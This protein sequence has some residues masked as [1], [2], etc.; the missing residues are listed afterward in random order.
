LSIQG[1]R[2]KIAFFASVL[3]ATGVLVVVSP[4]GHVAEAQASGS[5]DALVLVQDDSQGYAHIVYRT[6]GGAETILTSFAKDQAEYPDVSLGGSRI[7][8]DDT[9]YTYNS[10][11]QVDGGG[12]GI[13]VMNSDGSG[14]TQLTFPDVAAGRD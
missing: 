6:S 4:L 8:F 1:A 13:W 5:A 9:L 10:S 7:A 3:A 14:Q 2:R 11:G 12:D